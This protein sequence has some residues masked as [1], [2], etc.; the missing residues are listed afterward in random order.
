MYNGFYAVITNLE[1][2]VRENIKID[3]QQWEIEENFR[4]M[5]ME[6]IT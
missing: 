6:F 1:G 5:K 4:I 2:D 3:K